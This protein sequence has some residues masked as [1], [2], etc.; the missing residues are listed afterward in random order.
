M[1]NI[2]NKLTE[3]RSSSSIGR[4]L[5]TKPSDITLAFD[6]DKVKWKSLLDKENRN[7]EQENQ[8]AKPTSNVEGQESGVTNNS[9]RAILLENFVT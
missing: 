4:G 5:S 9:D 6:F 2:K 8:D 3:G 7:D 1:S